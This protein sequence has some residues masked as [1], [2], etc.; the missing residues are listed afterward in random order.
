M[1]TCNCGGVP[2]GLPCYRWCDG[3]A[4]RTLARVESKIDEGLALDDVSAAVEQRMPLANE[5]RR[6]VESA[7]DDWGKHSI[8]RRLVDQPPAGGAALAP[9]HVVTILDANPMP[10]MRPRMFAEILSNFGDDHVRGRLPPVTAGVNDA[11]ALGWVVG[12][13][14]RRGA[15]FAE[16]RLN[17]MLGPGRRLL[18]VILVNTRDERGVETGSRLERLYLEPELRAGWFGPVPGYRSAAP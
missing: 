17:G 13:D 15:L 8:P 10:E 2:C 1:T 4:T 5:L 12:L 6:N 7:R 3:L 9:T 11:P 16:I 14:V 18:P